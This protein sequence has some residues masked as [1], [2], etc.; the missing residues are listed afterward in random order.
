L[1][2][3]LAGV[4]SPVTTSA[5]GQVTSDLPIDA[6]LDGQRKQ[7]DELLRRYT[8]EHPDVVAAKRVIDQLEQE[9]RREIEARR[10][11]PPAARS[12]NR[13]NP[14]FQQIKIKLAEAEAQVASLRGRAGELSA[15]LAELRGAA[16]QV[17]Q[18][19]AELAQLNRDYDVIKKNYEQLAQRRESATISGDVDASARMAEFHV[20]EPARINPKPVFPGRIVLVVMG[21]LAAFASGVATCYAL[22]R[23]MPIV[24]NPRDLR[25]VSSRPVLGSVSM[26]IDDAM[27]L[28][29]RR[30]ARMF[31]VAVGGLIVVYGVW[32]VAV[33]QRAG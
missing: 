33:L 24:Q 10:K 21:L 27:L 30:H 19:E 3:E 14:V 20:V 17:P 32:A 2:R 5:D 22:A 28:E 1:R 13:D 9:R 31:A 12:E 23:L 16:S 8:D 11:L 6:R 15:R 29:E 26:L 18:V 4:D 7:L 25:A